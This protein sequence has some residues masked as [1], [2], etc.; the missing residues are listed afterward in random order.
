MRIVFRAGRA[1]SD[2][3][4]VS[5]MAISNKSFCARE[6]EAVARRIG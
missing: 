1:G 4:F 5:D 6:G 3:Q 2:N